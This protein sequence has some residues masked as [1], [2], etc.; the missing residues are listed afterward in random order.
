MRMVYLDEGEKRAGR[1][2]WAIH[3]LAVDGVSWRILLEDLQTGYNQASQ[4]QKIQLP[5]K[6][7]SFKAWSE[8]LHHYAES[9]I[10]QEVRDYWE[11]QSEQEVAMLPVDSTL[12]DPANTAT[13]EIT[14]VLNEKETRALLQEISSTHRVQINEVLLA[15]LVQATSA[16]TG[17]PTLTVDLEGHGREEII[18][19][20]DL[21]RTVGWFTSIYPVHLNITG[22]NTSIA[23]LKEVKEQVRQ[24]PNK[25]VDY[26]ILRYLNPEM[27][28]RLHSQP[29]PSISFNYL[30][31][32][33]QMFSDDAMYAPEIGFTR[34]DHAPGSKR[35]HLIDVIGIVTDGKLHFTWVYNVGQFAK[36]TIQSVAEVPWSYR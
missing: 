2:F 17:H 23:A 15:A 33:D 24:I 32:F 7:T 11:R 22:A 9:G 21:S 35:S 34:L 14:V 29:T 25:G 6:S 4:A 27:R 20:V 30:G 5:T 31:Q 16:W 3:H 36:S 10:A 12:E 8:K 1:L 19:D 28:E 18:E 13:E 26:G